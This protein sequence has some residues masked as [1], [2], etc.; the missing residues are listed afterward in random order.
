MK[1]TL[2]A[3]FGA[4]F[5]AFVLLL[6]MYYGGLD[7]TSRSPN[8]IFGNKR[9]EFYRN[10]ESHLLKNYKGDEFDLIYVYQFA[11]S[12]MFA[13]NYKK[14]NNWY[15]LNGEKVYFDEILKYSEFEIK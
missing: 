5:L 4:T 15:Y 2:A 10:I 11:D 9:D 1:E 14:L 7:H 12:L 3:F 6:I 13:H 8:L